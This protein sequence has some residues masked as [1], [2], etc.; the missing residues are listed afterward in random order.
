MNSVERMIYSKK[1]KH[2]TLIDPAKKALSKEQIQ[3]L[4]KF[5]TDAIMLGGSTGISQSGLDRQILLIKKHSNIPTILFPGGINGLSRHAD[6]LFFMSLLNSRDPYWITGIQSQG[7]PV[8]K[9][10][11]I[12]SIPMAYII[13]EPGM[14]AGE[15]GKAV[16]IKRSDAKLAVG[17]ALA[18]QHMGFR[19]VYLEAG[20]GA[21][22][23]VP[24]KMIS[25]VKRSIDIALIAGGG[26]RT[27]QQARSAARA[28]ADIIVTGTIGEENFFMLEK[29]IA[30]IKG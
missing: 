28:G 11:G 8:V 14:K 3:V 9:Q 30:A 26:I 29:I 13:I 17:Y 6:A 18:A 7:A 27:P 1:K 2:F 22:R 20:S 12:E 24:P 10:L 21:D 19:L 25:T 16:P 23:P 4:E 5:G 15:V